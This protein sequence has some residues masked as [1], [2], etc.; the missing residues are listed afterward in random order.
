MIG[1]HLSSTLLIYTLTGQRI[2]EERMISPQVRKDLVETPYVCRLKLSNHN[3]ASTDVERQ[4]QTVEFSSWSRDSN[5]GAYVL[6]VVV[7]LIH[8]SSI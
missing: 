5:E 2:L 7:H 1:A 4:R 8:Q 3:L 6:V